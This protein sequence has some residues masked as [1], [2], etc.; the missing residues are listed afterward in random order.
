MKHVFVIKMKQKSPLHSEFL[1][2]H[3]VRQNK[4]DFNLCILPLSETLAECIY[5]NPIYQQIYPL[6]KNTTV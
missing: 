2:T 3:I 4:C 1:H 6:V 5:P